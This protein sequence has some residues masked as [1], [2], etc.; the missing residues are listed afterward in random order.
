MTRKVSPANFA[1][2][3]R[4]HISRPRASSRT[5]SPA[6]EQDPTSG[7]SEPR[8]NQ[9]ARHSCV[10]TAHARGQEATWRKEAIPNSHTHEGC[11]CTYRESIPALSSHAR[12]APSNEEQRDAHDRSCARR[13]IQR[14]RAQAHSERSRQR[15]RDA[16][17][18]TSSCARR[19][20]RASYA[21]CAQPH[22]LMREAH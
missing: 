1:N 19:T 17:N 5:F 10:R 13:T 15:M 3:G 21:R 20:D 11:R 22:I 8:A 16:H 12:C 9:E 4:I 18:P 7:T 2:T 6:G 14:K